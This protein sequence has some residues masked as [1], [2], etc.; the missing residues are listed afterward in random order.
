MIRT[1]LDHGA[2]AAASYVEGG[3][4][5]CPIGLWTGMSE[6]LMQ[7][8]LADGADIRANGCTV[9]K[10]GDWYRAFQPP[11][12]STIALGSAVEY[13]RSKGKLE[14]ARVREEASARSLK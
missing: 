14:I 8:L 9:L 3:F 6:S 4:L 5:L 10:N 13:A 2:D 7:Q 12:Q 1:F 11:H